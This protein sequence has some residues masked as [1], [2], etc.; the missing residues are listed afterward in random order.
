MRLRSE[1]RKRIAE[2]YDEIAQA[3]ENGA[4]WR[5]IIEELD[6]VTGIDNPPSSVKDVYRMIALDVRLGLQRRKYG[7]CENS[8][9]QWLKK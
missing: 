4:T 8:V 6:R 3:R 5:S 9:A 1:A 2:F 7:V